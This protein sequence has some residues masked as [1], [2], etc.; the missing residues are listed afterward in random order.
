MA[1]LIQAPIAAAQSAKRKP[2]CIFLP[3]IMMFPV[4]HLNFLSYSTRSVRPSAHGREVAKSAIQ[5]IK[6][7]AAGRHG[8]CLQ[9][10]PSVVQVDAVDAVAELFAFFFIEHGE[11]LL[12]QRTG[13][14]I[15]F[16]QL[17][18]VGVVVAVIEVEGIFLVIDMQGERIVRFIRARRRFSPRRTTL[19]DLVFSVHAAQQRDGVIFIFAIAGDDSGYWHVKSSCG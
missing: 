17:A 7:R 2:R 15:G 8:R 18:R 16:L 9:Q 14:N 10:R 19:A 5:A 11:S 4:N 13:R 3:V 6:T 12:G 1:L